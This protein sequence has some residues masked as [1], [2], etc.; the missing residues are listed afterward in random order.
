MNDSL[1]QHY[2]QTLNTGV[3]TPAWKKGEVLMP[4]GTPHQGDQREFRDALALLRDHA[5]HPVKGLPDDVD[6]KLK[7]VLQ[8]MGDV[9]GTPE[10][11]TYAEIIRQTFQ[12]QKTFLHDTVASTLA[13]CFASF[14]N[15]D[16]VAPGCTPTCAK[17]IPPNKDTP[18]CQYGIY[19]ATYD[20]ARSKWFLDGYVNKP[21]LVYIYVPKDSKG[22]FVRPDLHKQDLDVMAKEGITGYK[23]VGYDASENLL[24]PISKDFHMID[25]GSK[26][27][28]AVAAASPRPLDDSESSSMW[29]IVI[30]LILIVVGFLIYRAQTS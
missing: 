16:L 20:K 10:Y 8:M 4:E 3:E 22:H 13:G 25:I 21:G 12:G 9:K 2:I 23:F 17:G 11:D 5:M 7:R 19:M 14:K 28:G 24:E 18:P 29:W 26:P 15:A 1:F 30:L 6:A 27:K